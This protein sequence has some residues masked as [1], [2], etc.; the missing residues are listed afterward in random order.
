VGN[1]VPPTPE[2]LAKIL[3]AADLKARVACAFVAFAGLRLE[4]LGNYLGDDGLRIEDL[5]ELTVKNG[6]VSFEKVPMKVTVRVTLS[7]MGNHYSTFLCE[8]GC[9]YVKQYL[10]WRI[11]RGEKLTPKSPLVTPLRRSLVGEH[12][13]TTNI[14]D[15][16]RDSIR[17]AGFKWRPYVLRRYFDTRLM[18]AES[19]QLII[20]DYRQF[21]MGHRGDIE[22]TYTVNKGLS[23][24]TLEKMR[25][26]Y[27]KSAAKYL[28]TIKSE[29]G[30][31]KIKRAIKEELLAVVGY[32]EHEIAKYD[33]GKV[34]DE[35]LNK[36]LRN[37][38]LG[39]VTMNGSK[40]K[41]VSAG[42]VNQFLED[43]WEYVAPLSRDKVII[44]TS[45][46]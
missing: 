26:S 25:E 39:T 9:E 35:E 46:S 16:I 12:I 15:M 8:E 33:L 27:A 28:K 4:V 41:V 38:L 44:K 6:K 23:S 3:N 17:A 18:M 42:E 24:D 19:D 14:S 45:A 1:E 40:Q 10:E 2:Q 30:Q 32:T 43:G 11:R 31:D 21:W 34:T 13:R 22:H 7:K 36:A 5:P 37:K 20:R 29:I